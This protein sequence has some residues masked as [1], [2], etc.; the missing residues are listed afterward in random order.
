MRLSRVVSY[1]LQVWLVLSPCVV[2]A[3]EPQG[4]ATRPRH[5]PFLGKPFLLGAHRGGRDLWPENT[6][7]AFRSTAQRWPEAILETDARLTSDGQVILLHDDTVNRTTDGT[8]PVAGMTLADVRKLDAGYRF[9]RD[10]GRSFPYRGKGVTIPTLAEVLTALPDS[11]FEIELKPVAGVA[12]AVLEVLKLAKAEDRVLLASFDP[13]LTL[14]A[15]KRAPHIAYCYEPLTGLRMLDQLRRGDWAAYKPTADVL[16]LTSGLLRQFAITPA[17]I[18]AIREK[19]ILTQVHT[20]NQREKMHQMIEM[21]LD[22]IL[23]DR[24]DLLAEVIAERPKAK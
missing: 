20:I 6:L 17:E 12:E 18:R 7:V 24:P 4:A 3:E 5:K 23:T 11:R 1:A 2:R 21:G 22:S 15:Q 14:H 9:T 16:S 10:G 13:R 8:G 19:G